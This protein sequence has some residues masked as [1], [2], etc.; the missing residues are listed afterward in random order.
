MIETAQDP[1]IRDMPQFSRERKRASPFTAQGKRRSSSLAATNCGKPHLG[2]LTQS[3]FG[4]WEFF[5]L[6]RCRKSVNLPFLSCYRRK[7]CSRR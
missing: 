7:L 4:K 6:E 2:I 3:H 5:D 1:S